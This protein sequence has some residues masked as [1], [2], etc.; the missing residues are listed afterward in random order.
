MRSR[1]SVKVAALCAA[2]VAALAGCGGGAGAGNGGDGIGVVT[3]VYPLEWLAGQVGGEHVEVTNLTEPGAEPH[4]LELTPRQIGSV[5]SAD[6]VFFVH[7]LQPAVDDAVEQ[8]GGDNALDVGD[9]VDLRPATEEEGDAHAGEDAHADEGAE[10]AHGDEDAHADEGAEDAHGDE[11]GEEGHGHGDTD[12]HMWLDTDRMAQAAA[13]LAERLGEADPG[14]A[15]DYTANAERVAGRLADIGTEY[16]DGLADCES[17]DMVVSHAAFGYLAD[18]HDLHQIGVSGIDP[19]AEPSPAR[20][21][22]VAELVENDGITTVFTE[23]LTSPRVAETIAAET[24]AETAVLDPLE[25]IT[26]QSPG[27]DYPSVMRANLEA[28]TGALRCS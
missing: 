19:E 21:A 12:P 9:I 11:G 15:A 17:R 14:N 16:T 2:G 5:S 18:A 25:G 24:G 10:D 3:G 4:D 20:L 13:G 7:G 22:E 6:V 8:E 26:D 27:D 1:R 23:T 28:L